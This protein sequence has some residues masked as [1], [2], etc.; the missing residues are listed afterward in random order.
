MLITT[1]PAKNIPSHLARSLEDTML[2]VQF[3]LT[4][5]VD[6]NRS[7]TDFTQT[8]STTP[9]IVSGTVLFISYNIVNYIV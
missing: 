1:G 5:N 2:S 3:I 7:G 9:S 4:Q 8:G 6:Y